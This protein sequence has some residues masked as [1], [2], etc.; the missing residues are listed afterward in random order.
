M[1]RVCKIASALL[2]ISLIAAV[3][4]LVAPRLF[5]VKMYSVLSGSMEPAYSVGDLIYTVPT[6]ENKIKVGD[7]IT[8]VL[9]SDGTVA[10]HRVVEIDK[11]NNQFYTKGDANDLSDGKPVQAENILGVVKFSIPK[12]GFLIGYMNTIPGKIVTITVILAIILLI[13][14]LQ[15]QI[16][17]EEEEDEDQIDEIP[18]I[19]SRSVRE[20][21]RRR[22]ER[23]A[24]EEIRESRERREERERRE[25]RERMPAREAVRKT[26]DRVRPKRVQ[27]ER[28]EEMKEPKIFPTTEK[29]KRRIEPVVPASVTNFHPSE[30]SHRKPRTS[31]IMTPK[32]KE[33][34]TEA[35]YKYQ[36]LQ[37]CYKMLTLMETMW[38]DTMDETDELFVDEQEEENIFDSFVEEETAEK[39][40]EE[41]DDTEKKQYTIS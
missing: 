40:G 21:K 32:I 16:N 7:T 15:T 25:S 8:F 37:V 14:L 12:V 33:G 39:G 19:S 2:M 5:G 28:A 1:K 35:E 38:N 26:S 29:Q 3:L 9:N 6:D 41:F 34:A 23:R 10:T 11:E 4:V 36:R 18:S 27:P 20:K 30:L 13:M 17:R 24:G 22:P 31:Q